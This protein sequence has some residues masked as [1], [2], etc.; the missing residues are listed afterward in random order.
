MTD[1]FKDGLSRKIQDHGSYYTSQTILTPEEV[2]MLF[3]AFKAQMIVETTMEKW[4]NLD[5]QGVTGD[6]GKTDEN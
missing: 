3:E 5:C 4:P 1:I 6:K 2:Q